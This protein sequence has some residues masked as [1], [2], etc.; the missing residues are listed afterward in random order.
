MTDIVH[1]GGCGC[2][3]V[4]YKTLGE[5]IRGTLCHCRYCQTRTGSAFGISIFFDA[6]NVHLLQG[7]LKAYSFATESGRTLTWH[8]CDT[9]ATS[10][11]GESEAFSDMKIVFGGTFDPPTF[12]HLPEREVFR[13]SKADYVTMDIEEQYFTSL[14][15]KP[16]REET[17]Q[18]LTSK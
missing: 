2:G 17:N 9:C 11:F 13:R 1:Y 18:G 12:W 8:F 10:V 3:A 6:S 5:P 14:I 7:N 4:R 16:V 15:Y